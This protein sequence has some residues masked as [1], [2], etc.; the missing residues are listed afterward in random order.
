MAVRTPRLY[1]SN[2]TFPIS[3]QLSFD[4]NHGQCNDPILFL[5]T[6][7]AA[8]ADYCLLI[9]RSELTDSANP[10]SMN[11]SSAEHLEVCLRLK[12]CGAVRLTPAAWDVQSSCW[13]SLAEHLRKRR[14]LFGWPSVDHNVS[15]R[16]QAESVWVYYIPRTHRPAASEE[17]IRYGGMERLFGFHWLEGSTNMHD[18]C[19]RLKVHG[20]VFYR[21]VGNS[22]EASELG[23]VSRPTSLEDV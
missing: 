16:V 14:Y 1:E 18:Y 15:N 4:G 2:R 17:V 5:E 7:C 23:L 3:A 13:F 11:P 6:S 12:R 19:E 20:A 21:N 9:R 22:P 8:I 10:L